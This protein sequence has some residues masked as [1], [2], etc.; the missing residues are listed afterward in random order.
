MVM[1]MLPSTMHG[2]RINFHGHQIKEVTK[3]IELM[4]GLDPRVLFK[5]QKHY[6]FDDLKPDANNV[7]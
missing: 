2:Y 3:A 4:R 5:C 1:A 7:P 6:I